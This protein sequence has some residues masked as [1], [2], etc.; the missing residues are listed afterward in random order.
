MGVYYETEQKKK[1]YKMVSPTASSSH[2]GPP[3][4]CSVS[5]ACSLLS[6]QQ[7]GEE[8][9]LYSNQVSAASTPLNLP[10]FHK[11]AF[12]E[13]HLKEQKKTDMSPTLAQ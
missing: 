12:L 6:H 5:S 7:R 1:W 2:L 3:N 9:Q 8:A 11:M 13:R 4:L 10:S